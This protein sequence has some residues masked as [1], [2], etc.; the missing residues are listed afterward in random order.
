[1][2]SSTGLAASA[3]PIART[4]ARPLITK[5]DREKPE[6]EGLSAPICEVEAPV[7]R[8]TNKAGVALEANGDFR[9]DDTLDQVPVE[10]PNPV[11]LIRSTGGIDKCGSRPGFRSSPTRIN[12]GLR[13]GGAK[14]RLS[15][16]IQAA[17]LA[18]LDEA[19]PVERMLPDLPFEHRELRLSQRLAAAE[20]GAQSA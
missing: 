15:A 19:G 12:Q 11:L 1:M 16:S 13:G 7:E 3:R 18:R 5:A 4:W 14:G 20:T 9:I 6:P 2:K 10:C 8:S 17:P